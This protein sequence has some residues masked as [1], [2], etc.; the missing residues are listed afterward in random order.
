MAA[1]ACAHFRPAILLDRLLEMCRSFSNPAEAS[2]AAKAL[3]ALGGEGWL[4]L[5]EVANSDP[6][7]ARHIATEAVERHM[8]GGVA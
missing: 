1:R 6:G 8:L 3:A 2:H 5:Q 4:R 7:L